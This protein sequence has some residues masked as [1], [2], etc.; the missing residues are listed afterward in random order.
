MRN[1]KEESD[2]D[3]SWHNISNIKNIIQSKDKECPSAFIIRE[4]F[5]SDDY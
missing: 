2:E 3:D 4:G 1:L 5:C